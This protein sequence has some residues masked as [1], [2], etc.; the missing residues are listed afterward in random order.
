MLDHHA[1]LYR[2]EEPNVSKVSLLV[3]GLGINERV[4]IEVDNFTIDNVRSLTEKA[5]IMPQIGDVQAIIVCVKTITL[6]AQHAL[7]KILEEPPT[8]TVFVFC[9]P[10]SLFILP[11]V[12]SRF[13]S[14]DI[15]QERKSD[16]TTFANFISL[17]VSDRILE[18]SNKL[19]KKDIYWVDEI[20]T[21]LINYLAKN[22]SILNSDK[23][24]HLYFITEH[25]QTRGASNKLLLEDLALTL[26]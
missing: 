25:L 5:Y 6:E 16:L 24:S 3:D 4:F 13:L 21:G 23:L 22:S 26:D 8:T 19:S 2:L 1:Y 14:T 11:T 20:K 15:Y 18:I 9:I 10:L 17:K 7:L 12:L